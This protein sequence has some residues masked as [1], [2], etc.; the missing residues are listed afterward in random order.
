MKSVKR[1]AQAG[2]LESS[3]IMIIVEPGTNGLRVDLESIVEKQYGQAIR[4]TI[5]DTLKTL[6]ITDLNVKAIDKGALDYAIRAR[7]VTA[8]SRAD[9]VQRREDQP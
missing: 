8:L 3:D 1:V 7:L 4:K 9:I 6:G 2:T 5:T